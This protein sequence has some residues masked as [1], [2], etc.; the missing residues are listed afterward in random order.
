M[1]KFSN[2]LNNYYWSH[3]EMLGKGSFGKVYK[4]F[5]SNKK[6]SIEQLCAIKIISLS[7]L[8]N[9]SNR[10]ILEQEIFLWK[11]LKKENLNIPMYIIN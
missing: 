6:N 1:Q 10:K 5:D 9:L 2:S 3:D 11:E 4:A 7:E 8:Q